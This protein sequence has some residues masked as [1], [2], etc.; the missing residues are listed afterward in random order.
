MRED[1]ARSVFICRSTGS[2]G[3]V[4]VRLNAELFGEEVRET[5][6]NSLQLAVKI[7]ILVSRETAELN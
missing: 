7:L 1:T 2:V 6:E 3:N 5:R 4:P